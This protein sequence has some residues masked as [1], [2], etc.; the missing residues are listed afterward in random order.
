MAASKENITIEEDADMADMEASK[1]WGIPDAQ[2]SS[3]SIYHIS[4]HI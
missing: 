3:Y 1:Q 4:S 2:V